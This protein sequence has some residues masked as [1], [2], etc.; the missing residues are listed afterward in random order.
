MKKKKVVDARFAK[1]R[2]GY[3]SVI[4]QIADE[5]KCPFCPDNFR[6][7][8][9]PILKRSGH[10]FLTPSTWPYKDTK[11]HLLII[12]TQHK[13]QLSELTPADW[14]AIASLATH[15]IKKFKIPGGAITMRFGETAYTG[16]SVC[17]LHAHLI[18]P[19]LKPGKR[20]AK[21]V[22]FPIG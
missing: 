10:W 3:L 9:K 12:G 15:A 1:G 18:V 21:T 2:K 11:H 5:A 8:K 17:H 4:N 20:V 7:H 14:R 13:E 16:A 6:Y 19:K 22:W